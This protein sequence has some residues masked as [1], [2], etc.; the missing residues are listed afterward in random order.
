LLV[1]EEQGASLQL[2]GLL[3]VGP[4]GELDLAQRIRTNA[5]NPDLMF[6][7]LVVEVLRLGDGL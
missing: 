6:A 7:H 5:G 1:W 2:H 4:D 3:A